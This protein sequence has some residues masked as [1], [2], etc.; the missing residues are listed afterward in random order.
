LTVH[1]KDGP[2]PA[3]RQLNRPPAE[4]VTFAMTD[5]TI[6]AID[7]EIRKLEERIRHLQQEVP[8]SKEDRN[9]QS[10]TLSLLKD[11]IKDLQK[12]KQKLHQAG[13]S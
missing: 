13:T 9:I 5:D 1:K 12:Q 11:V 3:V 6:R 4:K 10:A 8:G 7:Q 2:A